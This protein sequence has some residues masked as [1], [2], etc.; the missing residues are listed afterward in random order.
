MAD[1]CRKC[2]RPIYDYDTRIHAIQGY[3]ESRKQGGTNHVLRKQ[4]ID[5]WSG[6]RAAGRTIMRKRRGHG[7]QMEL[8]P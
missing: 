6:T 4:R 2:G 1:L 5:G 8:A 7:D 3:E